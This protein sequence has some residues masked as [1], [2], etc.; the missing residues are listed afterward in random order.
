M[1]NRSAAQNLVHFRRRLALQ[2]G[3]DMRVRVQDQADLR[4]AKRFHDRARID[5][6]RAAASPPCAAGRDNEWPVGRRLARIALNRRLRL[7]SPS[8]VPT[9]DV[10][11]SPDSRHR[12]PATIRSTS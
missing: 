1:E 5:T 11:T 10:K 12:A 9:A 2:G 8:G 4:V 7:R 3:H 6:L